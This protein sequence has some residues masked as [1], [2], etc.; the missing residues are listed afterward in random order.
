MRL[1]RIAGLLALVAGLVPGAAFANPWDLFGYNAKAIG[2]GGAQVAVAKDFTATYY[3]PAALTAGDEA[4]FGFGFNVAKPQLSLQFG[5]APG[6]TCL[7]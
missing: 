7:S 6:H 1:E 4:N 3:N 2:M 5:L